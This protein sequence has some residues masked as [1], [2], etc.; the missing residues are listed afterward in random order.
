MYLFFYYPATDGFPGLCQR[1]LPVA[2]AGSWRR[3]ETRSTP[4]ELYEGEWTTMFRGGSSQVQILSPQFS[5]KE[6]RKCISFLLSCDRRVPGALPTTAAS[7]RCRELA[8]ARNK[9]Y[10][11]R[12][13]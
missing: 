12:I 3:R 6:I 4:T 8:K 11:D 10:T 2:D 7:G 13:V 1:P 5:C 9:E